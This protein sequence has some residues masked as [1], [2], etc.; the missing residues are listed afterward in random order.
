MSHQ[1]FLYPL[2]KKINEK[3]QIYLTEYWQLKQ[4]NYLEVNVFHCRWLLSS[5]V[6]W[7]K[8]WYT[9]C[10]V[11][12]AVTEIT[13]AI[14]SSYEKHPLKRGKSRG[15][16]VI[17]VS[18]PETRVFCLPLA[19]TLQIIY[20]KAIMSLSKRGRWAK[21]HEWSN[22]RCSDFGKTIRMLY[23]RLIL[24]RVNHGGGMVVWNRHRIR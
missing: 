14:C 4:P 3:E 20:K 22:F 12:S 24:K 6:Y 5:K 18:L 2:G 11:L 7:L 1:I 10:T 15:E 21:F 16:N 13:G 8:L 17:R 19:L 9:T 23:T